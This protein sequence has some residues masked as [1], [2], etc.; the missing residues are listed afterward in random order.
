[1]LLKAQIFQIHSLS[2]ADKE[3]ILEREGS[4]PKG[5]VDTLA[6]RRQMAEMKP[7]VFNLDYQLQGPV[8][9]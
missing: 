9:F 1:M 5:T 7:L 3:R 6:I 2:Q 4:L 8:G